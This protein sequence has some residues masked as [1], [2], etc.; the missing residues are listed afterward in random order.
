[1]TKKKT[2]SALC[3]PVMF[4]TVMKDE[5]LFRVLLSRIL[6]ERKIRRLRL[7]DCENNV[8]KNWKNPKRPLRLLRLK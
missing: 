5:E 6:P 4:S 2:P 1:M 8:R 7:H 3:N